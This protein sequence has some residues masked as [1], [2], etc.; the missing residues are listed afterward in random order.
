MTRV[1]HPLIGINGVAMGGDTPRVA[2]AHRYADAVL[3]AGGI[4]VVLAP[5]GGPSDVQRLVEELDGLLLSGGDDFDMERF[6]LGAT[7]PAAQRTPGPKQDFDVLLARAALERKL[8]VLGVCYGMQL[9]ALVEG[10]TLHQHLPEDRAG[11]REHRGGAVHGVELQPA[12][13]LARVVG[14]ERL[15]VVSRHHQAVATLGA[16]WRVVARDDEDLI[17]AIERPDLPFAIGVQWHPE[18]APE[19]SPHDRLFRGLIGAAG[20]SA[21]RRMQSA[22]GR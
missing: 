10:G 9:L 11:K 17:E 19:G 13:K 14:V 5:V 6:G 1:E 18:L 22:T 21:A 2:L 20:V 16:A 8:P 15:D 3:K 4:P 7:H 12:S